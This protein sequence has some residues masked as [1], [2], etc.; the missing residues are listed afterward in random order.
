MYVVTVILYI[1][2]FITDTIYICD[3]FAF[4]RHIIISRSIVNC[5]NTLYNILYKV[6][7]LSNI[8]LV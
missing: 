8:S 3:G 5:R 4:I 6:T 7:I 1:V 2:S